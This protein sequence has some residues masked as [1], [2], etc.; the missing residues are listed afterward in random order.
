MRNII[1]KRPAYEIYISP[2]YFVFIDYLVF[3][4]PSMLFVS[5]TIWQAIYIFNKKALLV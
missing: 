5:N 1:G 3:S 4:S 2:Y